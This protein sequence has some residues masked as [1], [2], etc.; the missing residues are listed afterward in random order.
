MFYEGMGSFKQSSLFT[1]SPVNYQNIVKN[2]SNFHD[3]SQSAREDMTYVGIIFIFNESH[4]S[5]SWT[6]SGN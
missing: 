6:S 5:N 3:H 1:S 4:P 2:D